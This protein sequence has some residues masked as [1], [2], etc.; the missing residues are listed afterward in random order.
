MLVAA[1]GL[2]LQLLPSALAE[3]LQAQYY[4]VMCESCTANFM[5]PGTW[6][7]WMLENSTGTAVKSSGHRKPGVKQQ[8]HDDNDAALFT[9][10]ACTSLSRQAR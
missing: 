9:G 5:K 6:L 8:R 1:Q 10:T 7:T 3:H 2:L 4:N